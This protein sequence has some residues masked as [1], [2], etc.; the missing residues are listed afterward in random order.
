M[1]RLS[2]DWRRPLLQDS[3]L[4]VSLHQVRHAH[5]Q[6]L[7]QDP[8]EET[9]SFCESRMPWSGSMGHAASSGM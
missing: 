1:H 4:R 2:A 8:N 5:G 7:Q 3:N 9:M 6:L